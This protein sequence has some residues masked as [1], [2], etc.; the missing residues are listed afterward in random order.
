MQKMHKICEMASIL[1]YLTLE[2][3]IG[4]IPLEHRNENLQSNTNKKP[5]ISKMRDINAFRSHSEAC[6]R[7]TL[8][9]QN[10]LLQNTHA[11]MS[12]ITLG[13]YHKNRSIEG[14]VKHFTILRSHQPDF[15][16]EHGDFRHKGYFHCRHCRILFFQT[17]AVW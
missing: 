6:Q 14:A 1:V 9:K 5:K 11:M 10:V 12:G 16:H 2:V 13:D 3:C 17:M 8:E 7:L 4:L 15:P